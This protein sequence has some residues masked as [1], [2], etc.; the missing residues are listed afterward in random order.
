MMRLHRSHLVLLRYG[1]AV[2]AV[3]A[4]AGVTRVLAG[5]G[6]AGIS[7]PF[8]AA[9][10]LAAWV[11]GT[12]P[13]LLATGLSGLATGWLLMSP[14]MGPGHVAGLSVGIRDDLIRTAVFTVVA[15]LTSSLHAATRRAAEEA[16]RAKEAA[17]SAN[18][19]KSRFL[20]MV[21]HELR[22][23][24]SPVTMLT[25][26]LAHDPRLPAPLLRDVEKI[27]RHVDLE[28]RLIDDLVDLTRVSC[29]RL[30]ILHE[31]VD[32]HQAIAA[33]ADV[34]RSDLAV[35]QLQLELSLDA[36]EHAVL[37]DTV[38]LQQVFWN[39]LRNAIKFTPAGGRITIRTHNE[40]TGR[41]TIDICDTGICIEPDH[42][43][44]IFDA[45]EQGQP[46]TQ[47]RFGGLGLGLAICQA[48]VEAHGGAISAHSEGKDRGS[49]FHVELPTCPA[50][51]AAA[52]SLTAP[53]AHAAD[54]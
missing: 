48:L 12:G 49:T 47:L 24:L 54:R 32:V 39:L 5:I 19:A 26:M 1:L 53:V 20:A 11:G 51:A 21:S 3:A 42:L 18:A 13:G 29:G 14:R 17:E 8:F 35:K 27:R 10:V 31:P 15:L 2:L 40:P 46:D 23:P 34:C 25:E 41:L 28:V 7:P 36:R 44:S 38:R 45:F 6:D 43:R 50:P 30:R 22:T 4:A 9:V 37:G 52:P 16:R 33:A